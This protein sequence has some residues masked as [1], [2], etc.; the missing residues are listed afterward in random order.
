MPGPGAI[1]ATSA[2]VAS[3]QV[4]AVETVTEALRRIDERNGPLGAVIALRADEALAEAHALDERR[5][6]TG[7][8]A[9]AL[10]GVPVLVKDLEDVVGMPTR[11]GSL[12]LAD[13][14]PALADEVVPARLRSAGAIIVGKSNLPEF[15]TEGFTD[16]LVDGPTRNPWSTDYS[17][18][19]SSGGSA[20]AI[21]AGLVPIG[22]ATDGGGS[23][24]IPAAMC[25][26][27]GLKPTHGAIGRWPVPDW[28]DLSTYGPMATTVDDLR[29]LMS[30]MTGPVYGDP[31]S[32]PAP[33][34]LARSGTGGSPTHIFIA[35]RTSPLGPLPAG[36]AAAFHT[37][38]SDFSS[39]FDI[40][41]THLT[42][43][44]V[45]GGLGDP[46]LDWF[47]LATADHVNALGRDRVTQWLD[48][49]HPATAEFMRLGLAVD[50]DA[51]GSARRRRTTYTRRLDELLGDRGLLL[52]PTVAVEGW[53]ADGRLTADALPGLLPPEVYSTAMHNLTGHPAITLPAGRYPG[54]IPYGL[55]AAAARWRD[56]LL[57]DVA[58]TWEQHHPWPRTA[59]GFD[60]F[61]IRLR[62]PTVH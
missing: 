14:T 3:G 34:D 33:W 48:R 38:A 47:T 60:E 62:P 27:V 30:V 7:R 1:R 36:V 19:G 5:A 55:Q 52:T 43:E 24:R 6:R 50:V 51:Y 16:N 32:S 42:S 10:D 44:E 58:Q 29:L 46:D 23:V 9:G 20:A 49:M 2:A 15:A 25:G 61:S 28:I 41:A 21:S 59:P 56:D 53:L 11:R 26:L 45:F 4:T 39:M 8:P 13:A 54:G 22:T 35:E 18:G 31:E 57:L 37:A 12:M 17:P 40:T